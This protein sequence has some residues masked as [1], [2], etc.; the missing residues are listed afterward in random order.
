MGEKRTP[1]TD[2]QMGFGF[3][4]R[5]SRREDPDTSKAAGRKAGYDSTR[6]RNICLEVMQDGIQRLDEEIHASAVFRG[7]EISPDR[8]RHGRLELA[9][10]GVLIECGRRRTAQ[11][12]TT[13]RV[14]V[15]ND[16]GLTVYIAIHPVGSLTESAR[17]DTRQN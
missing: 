1:P 5:L 2:E 7:H 6:A 15:L 16:D 12:R 4:D 11:G 14:W 8:L 17:V 3:G 10:L 9:E 13:A